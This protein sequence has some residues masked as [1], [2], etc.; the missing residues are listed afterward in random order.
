MNHAEAVIL[1]SEINERL[2]L[3]KEYVACKKQFR[4]IQIDLAINEDVPIKIVVM[5]VCEYWD[6]TEEQLKSKARPE[7]ISL[8]RQVAMSLAREFDDTVS[9]YDIADFFGRTH[10]AVCHA[11]NAV[12]ARMDTDPKFR[13]KVNAIK[14]DLVETA[15][16]H[17]L[18]GM[19]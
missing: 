17:K 2:S 7:H 6:V 18:K 5:L 16:E 1:V 12:R 14:C 9:L 3:L 19:I 15:K 4:A 11:I 13:I 8:P 10:G